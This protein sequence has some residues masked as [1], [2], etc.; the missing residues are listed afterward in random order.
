MPTSPELAKLREV[1]TENLRI[2]QAGA[3]AIPYI[4]VVHSLDD[5]RARQNHVIFGRRGC[6]KTLLLQNG[7]S[8]SHQDR[9]TIYLNCEDFKNHSF[10]NV[11]IEILDAVFSEMEQRLTG[12]FGKKRKSR[13]LIGQIRV[14]LA[15]LKTGDDSR[16]EKVTEKQSE[17]K[18]KSFDGGYKSSSDGGI[19][20]RVGNP[21]AGT[22]ASSKS[23]SGFSFNAKYG[24]NN[25]KEIER[26]Y[27]RADDK[28]RDL[29]LLLPD[30]KSQLRDFFKLSSKIQVIFIQIDDFYHL[31]KENQP[32]IMDYVHRLCK[33]LPLYFKVAT[34][35]HASVLYAERKG[36]PVGAQERHDYQAIDIDFTFQD[37]KKT[38]KQ[39]SAI[40]HEFSRLAGMPPEQFDGL[41]QGGGFRRL[42][43][44]GGGVPRDCLSLFLE[45]LGPDMAEDARIGKDDI[46]QLSFSNF[47]KKVEDLKRDSQTGEQD[48]LL[49]GIHVI[50]QFCLDSKTSVFF[51]S[52]R[53]IQELEQVRDLLF[54]L[55]DY[56]I[57]HSV[58]SALT[59]KSRTGSYQGF[60]IDIGCYAHMRKLD[61]K[62][63]EIDLSAKDAKERMRSVPV[64]SEES[65]EKLWRAAPNQVTAEQLE[66]DIS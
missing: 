36:Q 49:K 40:F 46:R 11:L 66:V 25:S 52:D 3:K 4:D 44:A 21:A 10:P 61:N 15:R 9:R 60:M 47:Q 8:S 23:Q 29:N 18:D 7:A 56:R 35:R 65:L 50:R 62:M 54:R 14:K 37:F 45:A 57:I 53:V 38:E 41:F 34:L 6:G 39:V 30:L 20:M 63:T 13:E 19:E 31:Q 12:W 16:E 33:D 51:V 48:H 55:L 59:H 24:S 42:V 26:E 22:S 32:F 58:G 1:I 43:L 27:E 64:L 2:Q 5:V 17:S 28:I